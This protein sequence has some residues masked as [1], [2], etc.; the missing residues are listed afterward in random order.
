MNSMMDSRAGKMA[1]IFESAR[2]SE[3]CGYADLREGAISETSGTITEFLLEYGACMGAQKILAIKSKLE[4]EKKLEASYRSTISPIFA[5]YAH[6]R[7]QSMS[8]RDRFVRSV[9]RASKC[10][11]DY[12]M[13]AGYGN[14]VLLWKHRDFNRLTT[15]MYDAAEGHAEA[16][17]MLETFDT[18]KLDSPDDQVCGQLFSL[19][20]ALFEKAYRK[21]FDYLEEYLSVIDG[22][23]RRI[24]A[25]LEKML[26]VDSTVIR[27]GIK[28]DV[29][30]VRNSLAHMMYTRNGSTF[31]LTDDTGSFSK[32]FTP[33]ELYSFAAMAVS[34]MDAVVDI[35]QALMSLAV[36]QT[37]ITSCRGLRE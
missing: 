4:K 24:Y 25:L 30:A 17:R 15:L 26:S 20:Q 34:K 14:P 1:A 29:R 11:E 19:V 16:S 32:E 18:S 8:E 7:L 5:L 37:V 36:Y 23:Q 2:R 35:V 6:S 22:N 3:G 9:K 21:V 12:I 31:L 27:N 28:S 10:M 33:K 13:N